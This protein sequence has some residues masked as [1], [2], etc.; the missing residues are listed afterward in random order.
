VNE[1]RECILVVDDESIIADAWK[2]ILEDAGLEI[3]GTAATAAEAIEM[4]T[5]HRPRVV[6]MDVRLRGSRDG[7]DAALAIHDLVGSRVI[8]ITGSRDPSTAARIQLDH[9]TAVL[10]KPVSDRRLEMEVR[11]AMAM[12]GVG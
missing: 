1:L 7:V 10:F 3:C 4:A 12:S 9:P 5:V 11:A 6:L 8:F 2:M